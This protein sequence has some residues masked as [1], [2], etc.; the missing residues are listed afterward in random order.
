MDEG[1]AANS[2]EAGRSADARSGGAGRRG[3]ERRWLLPP[4]P[5]L[6][7]LF[8]YA[9]CRAFAYVSYTTLVSSTIYAIWRVYTCTLVALVLASVFYV[10]RG[11]EVFRVA[12]AARGF[13]LAAGTFAVSSSRLA[14]RPRAEA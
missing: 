6:F 10:F 14:L 13:R 1:S 11:G 12:G 9:A 3:A 5:A 7:S 4:L 2:S 8:P